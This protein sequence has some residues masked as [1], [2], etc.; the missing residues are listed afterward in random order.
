MKK[1]SL[2][3]GRL[4]GPLLAAAV[5]FSFAGTLLAT[6]TIEVCYSD[7]NLA[8]GS[9]AV[10]VA[11]VNEDGF[12]S[13]SD[14]SAVGTL[15]SSGETI[16]GS[17]DLILHVFQA[18]NG[19]HWN[20]A[21]G[22][23]ETIEALDYASLGIA[24]G[25]SLIL[26]S[27]PNITQI[28]ASLALGDQVNVFRNTQAGGSGGDIPFVAPA[29]S[30]VYTLAALPPDLGGDFDP[31][32]SGGSWTFETEAAGL[33][34]GGGGPDDHGSSRSSATLLTTGVGAPGALTQGDLDYFS[35][36]VNGLSQVTAYTTGTTDTVGH[37]YAPDGGALNSPSEDDDAGE[38]LNFRSSGIVH[39]AGIVTL[40]V[41]GKN[42]AQAGDYE[43]FLEVNP[44]AEYQTDLTIGQSVSRQ[45]GDGV[46]TTS[47]AGQT[48][49][50]KLKKVKL[51][52]FYFEGQNDGGLLDDLTFTGT[53]GNRKFRVSY[54][55]TSDGIENVTASMAAAGYLQ[56]IDPLEGVGFRVDTKGSRLVKK[57]G[58]GSLNL[59]I[60]AI[61][62]EGGLDHGKAKVLVKAKKEKKR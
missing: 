57:K 29:D 35:V 8:N 17:D 13:P 59:S 43:V 60:R 28:G 40:G 47:G 2:F 21:A 25:K 3:P 34:G 49:A 5:L 27:F 24:P 19:A 30:G 38:L 45:I 4:S 37:L 62:E 18:E 33:P 52:R 20:G 16:G 56:N 44:L 10:L 7:P 11:D 53:K 23:L 39:S 32:N 31:Q 9:I 54:F 51:G 36:E 46:Y 58:R 1:V 48:V 12:L 42:D 15:L 6:V 22:I 55:K 14:T 26:Y 61:S 50:Q 41:R